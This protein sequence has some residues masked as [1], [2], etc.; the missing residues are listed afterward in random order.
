MSTDPNALERAARTS[1]AQGNRQQA[2]ATIFKGLELPN[3]T[4][5]H[6]DRFV[7]TLSDVY[8]ASS[9]RRGAV[10]AGLFLKSPAIVLSHSKDPAE[11]GFFSSAAGD[12]VTAAKHFREAGL[13]AHA[14]FAFEAAGRPHEALVAFDEALASSRMRENLY[15]RALLTMNRARANEKLGKAR[16]ARKLFVES[17]RQLESIAAHFEAT[18]L[19][20]RAFDCYQVLI[21]LGKSAAFENLAEGYVSCI[22]ILRE[23]HLRLYALQYYDD[24]QRIAVER[25]EHQAAAA[26][27]REAASFCRAEHLSHGSYYSREAA[28]AHVNAAIALE[29]QGASPEVVENAYI[30]AVE[31]FTELGVYSRVRALYIHTSTLN[32]PPAKRARYAALAS[33]LDGAVDDLPTFVPLPEDQR[34]SMA[35]PDVWRLDVLEH[36]LEGDPLAVLTSLLTDTNQPRTTRLRAFL[37]RLRV[38][39]AGDLENANASVLATLVPEIARTESYAALAVLERF[40][41]HE[42]PLVREACMHAVERL[43]YK[44]AFVVVRRGLAD[45]LPNV[46][47]RAVAALGK[48][49]FPHA[50]DSLRR[51]RNETNDQTVRDAALRSIARIPTREAASELID[52]HLGGRGAERALARTLLEETRSPQVD[53]MLAAALDEA[54]DDAEREAVEALLRTRRKK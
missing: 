37:A 45:D 20:E 23:D 10:C 47:K 13:P 39:D 21:S 24:F 27:H 33:M 15:A 26:I 22:R 31:C 5:A 1:L 3:L 28:K 12:H 46:Q 30:A 36:E 34:S 8:L 2:A 17:I 32:L 38:L 41:S 40:M 18:G 54:R 35:Y 43:L 16:E 11:L 6:V 51:I 49:V 19:R 42:R 48:L 29:H 14:G 50:F 7:E 44:R 25:G 52:A 4:A 53:G 9:N